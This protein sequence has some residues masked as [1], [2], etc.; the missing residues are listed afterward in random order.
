M[1][2]RTDRTVVRTA[3]MVRAPGVWRLLEISTATRART[4]SIQ[5]MA[6]AKLKPATSALRD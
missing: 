4:T 6:E 5:A 1:N 2:T 3:V